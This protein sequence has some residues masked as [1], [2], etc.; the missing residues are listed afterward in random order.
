MCIIIHPSAADNFNKKATE[1]AGYIKECV[2]K[3]S[4]HEMFPSDLHVAASLTTEDIIGDIEEA[5]SDHLGNTTARYFRVGNKRF[6]IEGEDYKKLINIAE[7][8]QSIR[9]I[10]DKLSLQ[11][12]EKV[13]FEWIKTSH[14]CTEFVD[15]LIEFLKKTSEQGC[16]YHHFVGTY[17]KS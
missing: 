5:Q 4:T 16:C 1:I 9:G 2:T 17:C 7:Q 12:V 10:R 6:G 11:Y 15:T 14:Y 13:I 3:Q 8:I